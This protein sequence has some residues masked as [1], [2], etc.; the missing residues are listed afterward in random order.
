MADTFLDGRLLLLLLFP[1]CLCGIA[2]ESSEGRLSER[3]VLLMPDGE[4]DGADDEDEDKEV[5]AE[6]QA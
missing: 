3:G 2:P 1:L 5:T 6:P 4:E